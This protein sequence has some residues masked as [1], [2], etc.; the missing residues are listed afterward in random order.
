MISLFGQSYSE[1]HVSERMFGEHSVSQPGFRGRLTRVPQK[2]NVLSFLI[3]FQHLKV[4]C[5]KN[6][7]LNPNCQL[8]NNNNNYEKKL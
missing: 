8:T 5:T 2:S 3:M 4:I 1:R 7:A 6:M